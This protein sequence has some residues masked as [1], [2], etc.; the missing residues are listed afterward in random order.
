MIIPDNRL[1][2]TPSAKFFL[3][4]AAAGPV[5]EELQ[6]VLESTFGPLE[7]P[8][9]VYC[10]SHFST[11]YDAE[12]GGPVWKF[13]VGL[14]ELLPSDQIV[15]VKLAAERL[16][17]ERATPDQGRLRRRFNLDPGYVNG[18]QVVLSTVKNHGHRLYLGQG[19]FAEVSLL[20]REGAFHS[21]PWTYPDYRTPLVLT[22]LGRLRQR[23]L[24]QVRTA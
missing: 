22:Y 14:R 17:W 19:V 5:L 8:S 10:F 4:V 6:P 16:Q 24:S 9:P 21:L 20:F 7:P 11:Y 1:H 23:Y 12:A 2:P 15:S 18:W 3:A 13:L